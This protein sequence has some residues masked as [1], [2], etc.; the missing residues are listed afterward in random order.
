MHQKQDQYHQLQCVRSLQTVG[1]PC[2]VKVSI[3][4]RKHHRITKSYVLRTDISHLCSFPYC[5][6]YHLLSPSEVKS[7]F[8][9][10]Q[11]HQKF[12]TAPLEDVN[13]ECF[14]MQSLQMPKELSIM[15]LCAINYTAAFSGEQGALILMAIE[16][17]EMLANNTSLVQALTTTAIIRRKKATIPQF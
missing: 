15:A 5:A 9:G 7:W 12:I 13:R 17:C 11:F 3:N 8:L 2:P 14:A 1:S 4:I 16:E 10:S 6:A